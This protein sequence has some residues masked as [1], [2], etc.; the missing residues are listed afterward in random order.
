MK[1]KQGGLEEYFPPNK[2]C[3][4]MRVQGMEY[5]YISHISCAS[6]MQDAGGSS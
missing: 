2:H 3:L 5:R 6:V 4:L 1:D